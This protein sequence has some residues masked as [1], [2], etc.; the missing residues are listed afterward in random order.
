M[1]R[2]TKICFDRYILLPQVFQTKGSLKI[3]Q[4]RLKTPVGEK[5]FF[6]LNLFLDLF[7]QRFAVG[8]FTRDV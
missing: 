2:R 3:V 4:G 7:I 8:I 1:N 5:K 6:F